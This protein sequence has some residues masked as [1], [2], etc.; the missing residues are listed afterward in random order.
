MD[1]ELTYFK[2]GLQCLLQQ[3]K[4]KGIGKNHP[5]F[6]E[7]VDFQTRL[8]ANL[9]AT[10][11]FGDNETRET[12]RNE[13][14]GYLNDLALSAIDISFNDLC[15][16]CNNPSPPTPPQLPSND[17]LISAHIY[18]TAVQ[19]IIEKAYNLFSK[20][21]KLWKAECKEISDSIQEID[22][23]EPFNKPTHD[24]SIDSSLN[25]L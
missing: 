24:P 9:R 2:I 13:I 23:P 20:G 8:L 15:E 10:R 17:F 3:L 16:I 22:K 18:I 12:D 11:R 25:L 6:K 5:I 19:N 4:A 21:E 14:I 7:A 1:D